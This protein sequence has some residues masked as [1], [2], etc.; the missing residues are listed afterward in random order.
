MASG[1]DMPL[2][3]TSR[4]REERSL[5]PGRHQ[6]G[7]D[8]H[9]APAQEPSEA[10]LP[11]GFQ[12]LFRVGRPAAGGLTPAHAK[13]CVYMCVVSLCCRWDQPLA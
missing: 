9:L 13:V 11:S 3:L 1:G 12:Q 10:S 4:S 6:Q 5:S 7:V 2:R 8:S